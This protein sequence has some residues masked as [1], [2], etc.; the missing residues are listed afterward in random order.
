[1]DKKVVLGLVGGAAALIGLAVAM[2]WLN[3]KS[4]ETENGEDVLDIDS[5]IAEIGAIERD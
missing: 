1:M 2:H 3:E 4:T 5:E